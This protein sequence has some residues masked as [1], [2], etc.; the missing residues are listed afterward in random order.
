MNNGNLTL[1]N[2]IV[3]EYSERVKWICLFEKE[4]LSVAYSFTSISN[5]MVSDFMVSM[6]M[7]CKEFGRKQFSQI[8]KNLHIFSWRNR[9]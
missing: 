4:F 9:G 7:N 1:W 5:Q 2:T 3:L 8:E 6:D